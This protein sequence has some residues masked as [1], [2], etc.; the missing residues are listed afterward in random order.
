MHTDVE[1]LDKASLKV[2]VWSGNVTL[3]DVRLRREACYALGLPVHIKLGCVK[4]VQVT[5]PWS[6]LGSEPVTITLDG[7][8]F[9]AG[10]LAESDWDEEAQKEWAWARKES[11]LNRLEQA[12]EMSSMAAIRKAATEA[13]TS[14]TGEGSAV[15]SSPA[16]PPSPTK[17]GGGRAASLLAQILHNLQVRVTNLHVRYEDSTNSLESPFAIGLHVVN[18]SLPCSEPV[19]GCCYAG[20]AAACCCSC[21]IH[22][23]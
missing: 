2:A 22:S 13:L 7:V 12:A 11:R 5:I 6:K 19:C 18:W 10:P 3:T 15:A 4:S 23:G 8:Y 1:G 9:V 20:G 14:G 17:G 21:C 16:A